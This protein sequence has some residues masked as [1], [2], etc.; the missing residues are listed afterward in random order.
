MGLSSVDT[1]KELEWITLVFEV[2]EIFIISVNSHVGIGSP[3]TLNLF[4]SK[5][6][7]RLQFYLLLSLEVA[8]PRPLNLDGSNVVHGK[9]M[10]L[11][12]SSRQ[13]HLICGLDDGGTEISQALIFILMHDIKR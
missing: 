7:L 13:R 11:E 9:P 1:F 10:I 12:E 5:L 6:I 8:S 4:S 3:C 2:N